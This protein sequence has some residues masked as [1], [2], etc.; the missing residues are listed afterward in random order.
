MPLV[1]PDL[2]LDLGEFSLEV[3]QAVRFDALLPEVPGETPL[4]VVATHRAE[5]RVLPHVPQGIQHTT[6]EHTLAEGVGEWLDEIPAE[7][8]HFV[9]AVVGD[10]ELQGEEQRSCLEEET[11]ALGRPLL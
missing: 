3:P 11:R 6:H 2:S 8:V 9:D 7:P 5:E 4:I 1:Q 10:T